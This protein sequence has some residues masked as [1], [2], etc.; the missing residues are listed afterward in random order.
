MEKIKLEISQLYEGL[1]SFI[2]EQF[3]R[4]DIW[5]MISCISYF[6]GIGLIAVGVLFACI[7]FGGFYITNFV[8]NIFS[9]FN[10]Q[11]T[12]L[13]FIVSIAFMLL[14]IFI[15]YK[16]FQKAIGILNAL[17]LNSLAATEDKEL[18]RFKQRDERLSFLLYSLLYFLIFILG[19][20]FLII[21]G[22]IFFVRF[23]FGYLIMLDEKC[24]PFEALKKS[25][26]ITEGVFWQIFIFIVPV[27]LI[28]LFIPLSSIIFLFVPLN[29]WI[30]AYLYSQLKAQRS[31]LD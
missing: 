5:V 28:T 12:P 23:A 25:W 14:F 27:F 16:I 24:S 8:F 13:N 29:F 2:N 22:I 7:G 1:K 18:P 6:A 9:I 19:S 30:F 4:L 11:A 3:K 26:N 17:M 31:K 15:A 21:P 10:L 20:I